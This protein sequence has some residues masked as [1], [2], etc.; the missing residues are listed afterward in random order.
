METGTAKSI[1]SWVWT[2]VKQRCTKQYLL[3]VTWSQ[4]MNT[5]NIMLHHNGLKEDIKES[6]SECDPAPY[7]TP[8]P[9]HT[10]IDPPPSPLF[11][12]NSSSQP[13]TLTPTSLFLEHKELRDEAFSL[14]ELGFFFFLK[15]GWFLFT[16]S[17]SGSSKNVLYILQCTW[18]SLIFLTI[19]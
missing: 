9:P 2:N 12:P 16:S 15:L 11:P 13:P 10:L 14:R 17:P 1:L 19:Q 4:R 5:L 8:I 18:F 3:V 6:W 7:P